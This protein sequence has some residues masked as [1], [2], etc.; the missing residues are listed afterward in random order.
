LSLIVATEIFFSTRGGTMNQFGKGL[1]ASLAIA[2][3]YAEAAQNVHQSTTL[4][5]PVLALAI[6][7]SQ[8]RVLVNQVNARQGESVTR[9]VVIRKPVIAIAP[10]LTRVTVRIGSDK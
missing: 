5:G 2:S 3:G 4:K 9:T 7:P 8:A 10:P 6:G 1:L